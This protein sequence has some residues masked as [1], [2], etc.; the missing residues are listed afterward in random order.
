[1]FI[2]K[3]ELNYREHMQPGARLSYFLNENH[4][5]Q[6]RLAED[7]NYAK[8]YINNICNGKKPLSKKI[9]EEIEKK[10]SP[11][12][13]SADFLLGNSS[14]MNWHEV[15]TNAIYDDF[16]IIHFISNVLNYLG[17]QLILIPDEKNGIDN[18]TSLFGYLTQF[19]RK[20]FNPDGKCDDAISIEEANA[21]FPLYFGIQHKNE[22]PNGPCYIIS[23]MDMRALKHNIE[24]LFKTNI[25]A[26]HTKFVQ[27]RE[28]LK[29]LKDVTSS[30]D[31]LTMEHISCMGKPNINDFSFFNID[32]IKA[33]H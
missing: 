6:K 31:E 28:N 30:F 2:S 5:T 11:D 4:I 20:T 21:A 23:I 29:L 10:Y 16:E 12:V 13:I 1:M 3:T 22:K 19:E 26:N 25:F 17:Y 15:L 9:A 14:L 24:Y 33:P 8:E 27:T 32:K 18:N 7:L